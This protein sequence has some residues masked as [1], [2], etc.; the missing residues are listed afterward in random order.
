[1]VSLVP[2]TTETVCELGAGDRLVGITRWCTEPA[3]ATA[4]VRKVGGTKNP[5]REAIAALAPDL[6]LCNREENRVADIEW[7]AA[8][9]LGADPVAT[10]G[11]AV[12]RDVPVALVCFAAAFLMASRLF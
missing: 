12:A 3:A 9:M 4:A 11:R 1:M 7:F 8:R 5:D 6:V 2:S 10:F